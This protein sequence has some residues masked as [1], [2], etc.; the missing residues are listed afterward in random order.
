M[1]RHS[2]KYTC[3]RGTTDS[4]LN[5][6]KTEKDVDDGRAWV[7]ALSDEHIN[8]LM[9]TTPLENEFESYV[10]IADVIMTVCGSE[11]NGLIAKKVDRVY[12][13]HIQSEAS[14]QLDGTLGD[15]FLLGT[16]AASK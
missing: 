12:A 9:H 1:S 5:P 10:N 14:A 15:M 6:T 16:S 8:D 13:K 2:L 3:V 4:R 7:G 11:I